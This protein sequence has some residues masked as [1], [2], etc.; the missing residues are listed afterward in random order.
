MKG[1]P[2]IPTATSVL[3]REEYKVA[4][5]AA[6]A[7]FNRHPK[8]GIVFIGHLGIGEQFRVAKQ[9][10]A[11]PMHSLQGRHFSCIMSYIFACER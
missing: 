10:K 6:H 7:S 4:F 3:I 1:H 9:N 5:K 11:K 8:S 2:F